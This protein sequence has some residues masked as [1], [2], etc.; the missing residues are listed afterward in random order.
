LNHVKFI[1]T[2]PELHAWKAE[3]EVTT[4]QPYQAPRILPGKF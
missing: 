1:Q 3:H 4:T 2:I